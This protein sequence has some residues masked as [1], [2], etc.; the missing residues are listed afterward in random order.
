MAPHAPKQLAILLIIILDQP[1]CMGN[2]PCL[3]PQFGPEMM[4]L[5]GVTI[6][7]KVALCMYGS[8]GLNL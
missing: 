5:L 8:H 7:A 6:V 4:K 3:I 1:L 2:M